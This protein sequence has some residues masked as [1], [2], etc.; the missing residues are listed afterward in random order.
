MTDATSIRIRNATRD[1]VPAIRDIYNEAIL[2]TTAVYRYQ[3]LSLEERLSWFDEKTGHGWPVMVAE[4]AEKAADLAD[5]ADLADPGP[6]SAIV[7]FC[8]FGPFRPSPAYLHT[9][10]D[11]VSVHPAHRGQGVGSLLL[12]PLLDAASSRGIHAIIAGI[13]STNEASIRLHVRFG[14]EKVAHLRGVGFKFDRWLDLVLMELVL[15]A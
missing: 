7:G 8:T 1:D 3:P 11:S 6:G 10:E 13:D 15:D 12:P 4:K 2:H 9:V 14:F 5:L